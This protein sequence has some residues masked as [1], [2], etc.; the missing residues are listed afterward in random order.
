METDGTFGTPIR[1]RGLA[2]EPYRKALEDCG[3]GSLAAALGIAILYS[4]LA[5]AFAFF[6]SH[7]WKAERLSAALS[8]EIQ[9]GP[10]TTVD[11]AQIV[12]LAWE[13]V[14]VFA[15]YT[16]PD[17]IRARLVFH[18]CGSRDHHSIGTRA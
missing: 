2:E 9:R 15:P 11:F 3:G 16:T 5:F 4:F 8:E 7:K 18:G 17:E 10:G 6:T 1:K 12:P 14:Y 13:R